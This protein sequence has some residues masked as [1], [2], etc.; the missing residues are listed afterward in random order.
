MI[1]YK[2]ANRLNS[3]LQLQKENG[4]SIGFVPTMGALHK[5]HLSLIAAS[6]KN[7]NLLVCSIF[8]NPAQFNNK[9]DLKRYPVQ[10]EKDI[11]SLVK[12]GCDVLF[13]PSYSEI[14][15]TSYQ[16]Q[17]YEL[18]ELE[19]L[20]EGHFRPGHYQGVCQVVDR[21]L[22]IVDPGQLYLGQK[23]FQQCMVIKKLIKLTNRSQKIKLEIIPTQRENDGLAM[24]SRNLRLNV[25]ER[26]KAVIIY[27]ALKFL[28]DNFR[29][30]PSN[31]LLH[32]ATSLLEKE[33]FKIDY[34][35]IVN[36]ETLKSNILEKNDIALIAVTIGKVRL[37]DNMYLD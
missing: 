18:G 31:I 16:V 21:L 30:I 12:A 10:I 5:G 22:D 33:G 35:E 29:K 37:I 6:K 17:K 36:S 3:Y 8:I 19:K 25:K 20:L 24:S 13:L 34:I 32:D 4:K 23:D 1:I 7:N 15:P 14:Y 27:Q 9:E 28:R 2:I 11:E 26:K